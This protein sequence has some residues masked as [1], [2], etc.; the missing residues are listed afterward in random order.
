MREYGNCWR[1]F[2]SGD[3]VLDSSWYEGSSWNEMLCIY[4]HELAIKLGEGFRPLIDGTFHEENELKGRN[5]VAQRLYC[6]SE[7]HTNE[8]LYAELTSWRRKKAAIERK[9]PYFIGSNRLLRLISAFVPQSLEELLQL[10]GFGESKAG[11]YGSEILE[12]SCRS[13][14]EKGFP[15]DWVPQQVSNEEYMAWLYKQKEQKYKHDLEQYRT[16]RMMLRGIADGKNLLQLEQE[17]ELSRRDLL[18]MMENLE[19]EGYDTEPLIMYELQEMSEEE[20]K[21]VWSAY[22]ELGDGYLK[23]VLQQVYGTD[24]VSGAAMELL[25]ERIRLIRIRFRRS[26]ESKQSVG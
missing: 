26:V 9:A 8:E 23:P 2:L 24:T 17:C 13:E 16:R 22:E 20:Q 1:D 12:I 15:L 6:Y 7:L 25:Y 18:E 4:R 19:K 14:R 21:R 11:E 3:D 10:P 5:H